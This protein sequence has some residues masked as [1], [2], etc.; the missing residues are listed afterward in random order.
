MLNLSFFHSHRPALS[1]WIMLIVLTILWDGLFAPL[2]TSSALL[3]LK[4]LPLCLPLRG[5]IS[6][7]IYTYQYCSMLIL[8]Y[9][10]EGVMRIF[11]AVNYSKYFSALEMIISLAFFISCLFYLKQFKIKKELL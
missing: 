1:C 5:L 7:K 10:S 6:G 4:L 2:H 11:D 3:C 8:L 9:F